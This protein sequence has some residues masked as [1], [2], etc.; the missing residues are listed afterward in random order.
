MKIDANDNVRYVRSEF[1]DF[2]KIIEY[3]RYGL[4]LKRMVRA[5]CVVNCVENRNEIACLRKICQIKFIV[6]IFVLVYGISRQ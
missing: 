4:I 2:L 6:V 3:S 1:Y 5:V